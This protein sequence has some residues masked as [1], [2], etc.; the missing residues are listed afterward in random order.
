[1]LGACT[2]TTIVEPFYRPDTARVEQAYLSPTA[3]FSL[4]T[5]LMA[6]PLEIYYPENAPPPTEAELERLRQIFR[7]AFLDELRSDYEIV[8]APGPD[9][10]H[11][12]A[13]VLDLKITGVQGAF[14]PT[15]R[16]QD[17]VAQGHLTLLMEFRDSMSNRVL[18]RAGETERGPSNALSD[19][20]ASWTEV[21][22]AARYWASLFR[23]FLDENLG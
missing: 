13:Q 14:T 19:G 15:G 9:V 3:D 5:K 10:M 18:A 23:T 8:S 6:S 16:L 21:E 7:E 22:D 17:I 12:S 1:M 20:E 2:T 4:Y 11:V